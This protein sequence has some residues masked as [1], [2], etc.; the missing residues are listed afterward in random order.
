MGVDEKDLLKVGAE[1]AF[2]PFANL[3]E[4]LF[5][6]AVD[7]IGGGW[8][9]TLKTRRQI[10]RLK[11]LEKLKGF[12]DEVGFEPQPIP[13]KI[14]LP[15][16]QAA[17]NEDDDEL[18]ARWAALLAN[19]AAPGAAIPPSFVE[20]LRQLSSPDARFLWTVFEHPWKNSLP[21]VQLHS[22]HREITLECSMW[23][24]ALFDIWNQL[25]YALSGTRGLSANEWKSALGEQ[26]R[27]DTRSF[28]VTVENLLRL[29][30]LAQKTRLDIPMPTSKDI[31]YG[32][33][34]GGQKLKHDQDVIFQMTDLGYEF[35]QACSQPNDPS[36][37]ASTPPQS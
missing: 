37:P 11:L 22:P 35:I 33:G 1:A 27:S 18:Q 20:I 13:D 19:A 26:R 12:I 8:E 2:K 10:R 28:N 5:G 4:R 14:W 32:E 16:L 3:I 24:G 34:Y 17:L 15:A 23:E 29:G 31:E 30:L 7:Q 6:G 25:G 9:D 36:T 21:I